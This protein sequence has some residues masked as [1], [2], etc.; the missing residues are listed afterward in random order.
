M[1]NRLYHP[2]KGIITLKEKKF[3]PLK[4][5][6]D[7]W[8]DEDGNP[9][10]IDGT[11]LPPEALDQEL[12][13]ETQKGEM[14]KKQKDLEA[15]MAQEEA[16][17]EAQEQDEK[18][19]KEEKESQMHIEVLN[20][21]KQASEAIVGAVGAI[22]ETI[23]PEIKIPDHIEEQRKWK[24]EILKALKIEFPET[25][26]SP[27]VEAIT[28][29]KFPQFPTPNDYTKLLKEI[30]TS[31]PKETDFSQIVEA[32]NSIQF[33]EFPKLKFTKTGSLRVAMDEIAVGGGGGDTS[34]LATE[35]K[36]DSIIENLDPLAS[37][38]DAGMDI[39]STPYYFGYLKTDGSWYIKKLDTSSG[40]TW[41][42]GN[43]DYS[44]AWS[45]RA[46]QSYDLYNIIFN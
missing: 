16:D 5:V 31:L 44:T 18:Q 14:K 23:I 1:R 22:P 15:Q 26:M 7:Q 35:A 30:K 12:E 41:T 29:I 42:Q 33:P 17:E 21:V 27:V 34:K 3:S 13:Q 20:E 37:Y 25:D 19:A 8:L 28:N 11:E 46:S 4:G 40:T 24:D 43:S 39:A 32:I 2:Q 45:N 36:Q 6:Q 38:K 9:H 10:K